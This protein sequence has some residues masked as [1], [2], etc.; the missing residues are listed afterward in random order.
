MEAGDHFKNGASSK[1]LMS[2]RNFFGTWTKPV[3]M[4]F[5]IGIFALTG[6]D[7]DGVEGV[8][9]TGGLWLKMGDNSIVPTSDIDFYDVSTHMIYLKKKLPYLEK[10][11]R[12]G[13]I[14]VYVGRDKIYNCSFHPLYLSSLPVGAY[15][16]NPRL[17]EEDIIRISF[18]PYTGIEDRRDDERIIAALKR[19]NQYHEGLHC[20]IQSVQVSN[21]KVVLKFELSNPDTFDYYYLDPDKMGFGLFH[22]FTNGPTFQTV[23]YA[24]SYTHQETVIRPEPWNSWKK[25]WLTLIKSGERKNI[26]ITYNQFESVPAGNYRM[27]F[28]FPGLN[29][30]ISQKDLTL[31]NGRI[32]M[33]SISAEK[34]V[35]IR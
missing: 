23:P 30:G 35:T 7:K 8:D 34:D 13:S 26:S 16:S 14:S 6:C 17:H 29:Y 27:Y 18:Q 2:R 5:V 21:G 3:V 20:E 19:Y 12:G 25:E 10:V 24:K 32:W 28:G 33:G 11:D 4:A 31:E 9:F 15:T 1:S 22:Y